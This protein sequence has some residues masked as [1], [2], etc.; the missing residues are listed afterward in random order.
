MSF[1]PV[2]LGRV[3]WA[4]LEP[5]DV[6]RSEAGPHHV[7]D[8]L[9]GDTLAPVP[10]VPVEGHELDEADPDAFIHCPLNEITDLI[11]VRSADQHL[12]LIHI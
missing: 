12:S 5:F 3:M 6:V 2:V 9:Q 1:D 8:F 4:V 10:L 7:K 11:V